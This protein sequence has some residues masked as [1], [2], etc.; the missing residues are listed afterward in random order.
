M[1]TLPVVQHGATGGTA[2]E[3]FALHIEHLSLS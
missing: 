1:A 2:A 3:S